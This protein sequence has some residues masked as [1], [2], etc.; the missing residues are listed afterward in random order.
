M[1]PKELQKMKPLQ[2]GE[3]L[4]QNRE[5]EY[6]GA[7]DIDP[8]TEPVVTISAIYNGMVTLQRGK[9]NKDVIAFAEERVPG[10]R[11]VRPL[12]VNAT[13]RKTLRKLFGSV[14]VESLVGKQVQLY[15]DHNVK[16]PSTGERTDG[17]RIRPR[18][19]QQAQE[20]PLICA[21]CGSQIVGFG[22]FT[23][24]AIA[25][26]AR[27][28][29]GVDLCMTCGKKRSEATEKKADNVADKAENVA[30]KAESVADEV[31]TNER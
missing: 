18:K 31:N 5:S 19:P 26:N 11:N 12:I 4:G 3:R 10:I 1:I 2:P 8:G 27:N 29:F 13:N 16:D 17:I 14:N 30:D 21:D 24:A 20:K 9:E 7:E 23:P 15:I 28:K 6:L 22:R 25:Q